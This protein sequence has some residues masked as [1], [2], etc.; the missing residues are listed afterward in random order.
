M[1]DKFHFGT[2]YKIKQL[3][4]GEF[5]ESDEAPENKESKQ[6]D[7][8]FCIIK[9]NNPKRFGDKLPKR[10]SLPFRTGVLMSGIFLRSPSQVNFFKD[11][12]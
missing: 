5:I 3:E 11:Q 6:L 2:R 12:K 1:P 8:L 7:L 4:Q 10:N 9:S